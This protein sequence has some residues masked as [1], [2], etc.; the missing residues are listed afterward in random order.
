MILLRS[1]L[2][3]LMHRVK[4]VHP[5]HSKKIEEEKEGLKPKL[6]AH[7]RHEK[8]SYINAQPLRGRRGASYHTPPPSLN[9]HNKKKLITAGQ[10]VF[11]GRGLIASH[12]ISYLL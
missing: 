5:I 6:Q 7:I 11:G 2:D 12:K 1:R 3:N 10:K 9:G 4:L 8:S